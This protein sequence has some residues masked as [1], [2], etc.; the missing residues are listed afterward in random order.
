MLQNLCALKWSYY[1]IVDIVVLAVLVVFTV[2]AARK[3]F[4]KCMLGIIV[5]VVGAVVAIVFAD[6]LVELSG[7]IFGLENGMASWLEG[8]LL[9]N[10][11]MSVDISNEGLTASLANANIPGFIADAIVKEFGHSEVPAGTTVA[12]LVSPKVSSL[13]CLLISGGLLFGIIKLIGWLIGKVLNKGMESR[14][15]MSKLNTFFGAVVGFVQ[16]FLL[17]C[18]ILSVLSIFVSSGISAF[19]DKTLFVGKLF[20]NNPLGAILGLIGF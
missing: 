1:Y 2:L 3:G 9:K 7:G 4:L 10:E 16:A 11:M 13:V 15:V 12:A 5:T 20:H 14:P 6:N 18:V 19:F 17:I 8:V